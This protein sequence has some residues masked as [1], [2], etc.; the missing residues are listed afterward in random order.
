[1][2]TCTSAFNLSSHRKGFK[3]FYIFIVITVLISEAGIFWNLVI[4]RASGPRLGELT[5]LLG[6]VDSGFSLL[7]KIQFF[8]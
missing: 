1:M 2:A 5:N 7:T 3:H 4:G 8:F 6:E